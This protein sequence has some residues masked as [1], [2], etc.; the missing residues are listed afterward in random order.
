L[1]GQST[2]NVNASCPAAAR[3]FA[4]PAVSSDVPVQLT[5][6]PMDFP[7]VVL[8]GGYSGPS[9]ARALVAPQLKSPQRAIIT[10]NEI[11]VFCNDRGLRDGG[12]ADKDYTVARRTCVFA[13]T[14]RLAR[15]G[16][17]IFASA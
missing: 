13:M 8:C 16:R 5:Q 9:L 7:E 11:A 3:A 1:T 10:T 14:R 6:F 17:W 2:I 15:T 12:T 4:A